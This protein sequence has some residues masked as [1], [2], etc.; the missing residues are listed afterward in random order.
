MYLY[1]N[2]IE[3]ASVMWWFT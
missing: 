1:F 3:N 2:V